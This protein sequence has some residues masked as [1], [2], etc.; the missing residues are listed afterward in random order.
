MPLGPRRGCPCISPS[1]PGHVRSQVRSKKARPGWIRRCSSSKGR[2]AGSLR[3]SIGREAGC[4]C[5]KAIAAAE[6]HHKALSIAREQEAKLWELRA[7]AKWPRPTVARPG[8]PSCC[9]PRPARPGLQLVHRGLR[10]PRSQRGKGAARRAD[11]GQ[12][13]AWPRSG[14]DH[15]SSA[16]RGTRARPK[17]SIERL[18]SR[19]RS[20][21]T[22]GRNRRVSP[23]A[24][25]PGEGPLTEPTAGTQPCRWQPLFMPPLRSLPKASRRFSVR[26]GLRP[27]TASACTEELRSRR[28]RLATI[29]TVSG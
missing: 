4:C 2:G 16:N 19:F 10:H 9:S 1:W 8:S 17:M 5:G 6:P 11:A 13:V 25:R 26:G 12:A 29:A 27:P 23:V 28:R 3:S 14:A 15:R 18:T 7:A 24:V 22:N 21:T 20:G